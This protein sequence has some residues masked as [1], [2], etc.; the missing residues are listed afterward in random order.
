MLL[1][2]R[3]PILINN[4]F[5]PYRSPVLTESG[6]DMLI[7]ILMYSSKSRGNINIRIHRDITGE[8]WFGVDMV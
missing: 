8:V 4:I 2:P 7:I 3:Y 1:L 5:Y 6:L